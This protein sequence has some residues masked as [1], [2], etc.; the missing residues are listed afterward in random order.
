VELQENDEIKLGTTVLVLKR[1]DA[2]LPDGQAAQPAPPPTRPGAT[3]N[4][5]TLDETL[6]M[7][8]GREGGAS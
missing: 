5:D 7:P 2:P 3:R 8:Y 1:L 6:T 4:I